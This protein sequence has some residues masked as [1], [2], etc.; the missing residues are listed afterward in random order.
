MGIRTDHQTCPLCDIEFQASLDA[1]CKMGFQCPECKEPLP[2]EYTRQRRVLRTGISSLQFII[3]QDLHH[4]LTDEQVCVLFDCDLE[5]VDA[6]YI[7]DRISDL[8]GSTHDFSKAKFVEQFIEFFGSSKID[9]KT[10]SPP[11][12]PL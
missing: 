9:P 10:W 1:V 12:S 3:D 6:S 7:A 2:P 4:V 11:E 5:S 8:L